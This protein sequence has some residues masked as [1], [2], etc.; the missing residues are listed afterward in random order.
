MRPTRVRATPRPGGARAAESALPEVLAMHRRAKRTLALRAPWR[1]FP[2]PWPGVVGDMF[3]GK[4]PTPAKVRPSAHSPFRR[5]RPLDAS[6]ARRRCRREECDAIAALRAS[7]PSSLR[8]RDLLPVSPPLS[9]GDVDRA[10]A[11]KLAQKEAELEM[12]Q[13]ANEALQAQ[14]KM[15]VEREEATKEVASRHQEA[16]EE[17]RERIDDLE[18][19][20]ATPRA[21][22]TPPRPRRPPPRPPP[23]PP[24]RAGRDACELQKKLQVAAAM[25]KK[26]RAS[27]RRS[28][29]DSPPPRRRSSGGMRRRP[30]RRTP[31][32]DAHSRRR[33]RARTPRSNPRV[34]ARRRTPVASPSSSAARKRPSATPRRRRASRQTPRRWSRRR[35][36]QRLKRRPTRKRRW[37]RRMRASRRRRRTRKRRWR[38]RMRASR[39]WRRTRRRRRPRR[40]GR[41]PRPA[42][43]KLVRNRLGLT[44]LRRSRR[45][46]RRNSKSR[47][48]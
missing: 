19:S 12:L 14:A 31:P 34:L 23:S 45:R 6:R 48:R 15:A 39:R 21:R 17:A 28:R 29:S 37:R 30:H 24:R 44:R 20:S 27:E 33:S 25:V 10:A 16:L 2:G 18:G 26:L 11:R 5:A 1:T 7:R 47:T 4:T 8:F 13:V 9:Q 43:L 46:R 41:L 35:R 40:S 22:A 3:G 32:R 36:R 42:Q 38:R